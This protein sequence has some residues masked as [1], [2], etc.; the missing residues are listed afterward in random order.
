MQTGTIV[1]VALKGVSNSGTFIMDQEAWKLN[2]GVGSFAQTL[3]KPMD[4]GDVSGTAITTEAQTFMMLPQIL[5]EGAEVEVVFRDGMTGEARTLD[6]SIAGSEWPR[7]KTVTYKL[8]ISPEYELEFTS[9][10]ELQDAHYVIYPIHIKA[11]Q[12]DGGWTLSVKD[13]VTGTGGEPAVTLRSEL[14]ILT[15]RGFWI[16]E[17]RG[18]ESVS[19]TTVGDDITVYAFL[20]ENAGDENREI[21]LELRPANYPDATP[22][23]F[24]ITQLCPSWNGNLGCERIEEY[25]EGFSGYPWGFLWPDNMVIHYNAESLGFGGKAILW[26][27]LHLFNN[28]AFVS[29]NTWASILGQDY[30]I[31]IDF[32]AISDLHVADDLDNGRE[33]TLSIYNFDGINDAS[34]MM[35]MLEE[36]GLQPDTDLPTNPTIFAARTCALKNKFNKEI[37]QGEDGSPVEMAVLYQ[38]NLV[39]Y[40]PAVNEAIMMHDSVYPLKTDK[41]YWTSTAS[42]EGSNEESFKYDVGVGCSLERRDESL[43]VRAVRQKP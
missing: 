15:N 41:A 25:D 32:N 26:F 31:T 5:P 8:S 11:G 34:S 12:I 10:P 16:E 42:I 19:S 23:T 14:T 43:Y 36:W 39:W 9:E 29:D 13:N 35:Q 30:T 22:K 2:E 17:D 3:D 40:L 37:G 18:T 4:V 20:A 24:T 7:G 33:N 38:N 28:D 1:S 21:T 27:Y 6:A